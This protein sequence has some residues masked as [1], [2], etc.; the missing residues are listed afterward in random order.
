MSKI[1]LDT[2][3]LGVAP[4]PQQADRIVAAALQ[5]GVNFVDTADVYGNMPIFDRVGAPPAAK[6][7]PA[8]QILGRVLR[9]R[10]DRW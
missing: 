10:R 3:T 1:C 8:E 7:E 4:D 9:G 6:R 2:A 5:L